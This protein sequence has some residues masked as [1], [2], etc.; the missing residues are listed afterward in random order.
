MVSA[1]KSRLS[2]LQGKKKDIGLSI[3]TFMKYFHMSYEET[4]R[5]PIPAFIELNK[6]AAK[7][8]KERVK[9]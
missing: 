8:E 4:M 6:N 2:R 3:V 9:E 5:L 7:L 1:I